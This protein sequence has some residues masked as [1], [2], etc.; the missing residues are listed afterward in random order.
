MAVCIK[1]KSYCKEDHKYCKKCYENIKFVCSEC[2]KQMFE[3]DNYFI[4]YSDFKNVNQKA[5]VIC[6][7]CRKKILK[8][9]LNIN[10]NKTNKS[11]KNEDIRI[12]YVA[13]YRADDG[14]I[15]RSRGEIIIDNYLFKNNISHVYEKKVYNN[16]KPEEECTTDFYLP[17]YDTYIE[18]WG[19]ENNE[20]YNTIKLYKEN[21]YKKN[22]YKIINVYSENLDSGLD[23][24]LTKELLKIKKSI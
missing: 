13:K 16:E 17:Q 12:K 7:E 23:D 10:K 14:H 3:E 1:C 6:N 5:F 8:I 21:I 20:N 11:K 4:I 2:K 15:V 19:I 22:N 24:Y 18:F 9:K